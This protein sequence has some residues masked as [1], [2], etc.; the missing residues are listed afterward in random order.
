MNA[1]EKS[2][3]QCNGV[4]KYQTTEPNAACFAYAKF[5]LKQ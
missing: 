2:E 3:I 5:P 4:L 1:S